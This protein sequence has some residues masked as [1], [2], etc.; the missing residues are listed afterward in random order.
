M[1]R[2][3]TRIRDGD[4]TRQRLLQAAAAEFSDHGIAGARVDRIVAAARAGKGQLYT[5]FTSKHGLFDA[6]LNAHI[7]EIANG[8]VLN[9]ADLAEYAVGLYDHALEHPRLLR[10]AAWSRLER[11]PEGELFPDAVR[12]D[13][14]KRATIAAAQSRGEIDPSLEPADILSMVTA[15]AL[16]WS[17]VS[18]TYAIGDT[19]GKRKRRRRALATV[20]A[21][22]FAPDPA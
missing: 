20:V 1:L 14:D 13:D 11:T 18:L 22:M 8:V 5:Y 17:S 12:Y 4:A 7:E 2:P 15:V 19:G 10:L 9:G 21:R 3:P 6:V 16:A